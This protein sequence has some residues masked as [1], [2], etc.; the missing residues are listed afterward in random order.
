MY[1]HG[2]AVTNMAMCRAFSILVSASQDG[3]LIIWDL[4]RLCYV[5]SIC[6]HQACVNLVAVSDTLGD[7][8]S[9]SDCG[10]CGGNLDEYS[11]LGFKNGNSIFE[12]NNTNN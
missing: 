9:V 12:V 8:I 5:R 3:T 7:I 11:N 10:K 2:A 1:G 6:H 4:N